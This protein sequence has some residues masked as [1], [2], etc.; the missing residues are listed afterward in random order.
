MET[1]C[2]GE[3]NARDA[4]LRES[5]TRVGDLC[6][7]FIIFEEELEENGSVS[8]ANISL[9]GIL[10]RIIQQKSRYF[11]DPLEKNSEFS[12]I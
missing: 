2:F 10:N 9:V 1:V 4:D 6:C 8:G 7:K 11:T 3:W 5:T 12:S